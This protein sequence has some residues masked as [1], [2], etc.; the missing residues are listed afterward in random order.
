V[1]GNPTS[2]IAPIA[3]SS[4]ERQV[5]E[6]LRDMIVRGELPEATP[7]VQRELADRL[8]VSQTPVRVALGELERDGLVEVGE[9]GRAT[10]S[11]LT[12]EDLEELYAARLGLEG[13]AARLGATAVDD[14][15]VR[16]MRTVLARLDRLA[17]RRDVEPYLEGRWELH[18]TCY[19]ASGRSRLLT[20]VERL[21][22]RGVRYHRLVLADAGRFARS[23]ASHH[24]FVAACEARDGEAAER[25]VASS[26][27]W[28]VDAVAGS[29]PSERV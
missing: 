22:R 2:R 28:A 8:G 18:A 17:T 25:V 21:F 24:D 23:I 11:R 12:R 29:L 14:G 16:A 9:T 27:R 19:G 1:S 13:L 15:D 4:V 5:A 20:E 6:A 3:R 26:M 7:L 10:V